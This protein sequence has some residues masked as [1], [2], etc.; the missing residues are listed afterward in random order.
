MT[1][2]P[3]LANHPLLPFPPSLQHLSQLELYI[4]ISLSLYFLLVTHSHHP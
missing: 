1:L 3:E 4:Y 2:N